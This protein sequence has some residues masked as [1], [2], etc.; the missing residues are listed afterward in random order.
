MKWYSFR[1]R[2][3]PLITPVLYYFKQYNKKTIG[4]NILMVVMTEGKWH[5]QIILNKDFEKS[6][7]YFFSELLKDRNSLKKRLK[8]SRE[9]AN[10]FLDFCRKKLSGFNEHTNEE[11]IELLEEYYDFYQEFSISNI[12]PWVFLT[13]K[14]SYEILDKLS[15][16]IK[17]DINKV[18]LT[19]STTNVLSYTKKEELD[20]LSFTIDIKEKEIKDFKDI[21]EF[22]KLVNN[23]FWIPFDYLGPNIWDEKYYIKRVKE[24]L[25]F[26]LNVLKKQEKEIIQYQRSLEIKQKRM[27]K[28]LNLPLDLIDLFE[29]LKDLTTLQ[30]EKK[31]ITTESHYYLQQLFKELAKRTNKEYHDFY[32]LVIE[33]IKDLLNSKNLDELLKQRQKLAVSIIENGKFKILTG[34]EAKDYAKENEFLLPSQEGEEEI[35]EIKGVAGSQGHAIGEIKIIE[36]SKEIAKFEKDKI[37]VTPMTTPDFVPIMNKAKAIIT[38]EGGITCHAAIVSRE[39]GI[40]CVIGTSIATKVLK[41]GDLVE[42]DADNGVVKVIKRK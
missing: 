17:E 1:K 11:L 27:I 21:P 5:H 20:V 28:E 12:A 35:D 32:Y 42:V 7:E 18:F 39:L 14:L 36:S 10:N 25:N 40:P 41:D 37:L 38:N 15:D 16:F 22:K 24:L 30:D 13:D 34:N 19:L 23:N 3:L 9:I 6:G 8:Q 4:T 33:E 31:A 29:A 26:D 2:V